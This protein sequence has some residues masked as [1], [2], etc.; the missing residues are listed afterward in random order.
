RYFLLN[1]R[2]H[3]ENISYPSHCNSSAPFPR[4]LFE[5]R[6]Q[7]KGVDHIVF[8]KPPLSCDAGAQ[9]QKTGEFEPVGVALDDAFD[10]I[11][12]GVGPKAPVHVETIRAGV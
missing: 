4:E 9:A 8:R 10:T 2:Q 3:Y 6:I 12:F 11:G 5:E 7:L 1:I